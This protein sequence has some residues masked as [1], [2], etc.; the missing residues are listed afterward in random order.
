MAP[1]S[2]SLRSSTHTF[3]PAFASS[4]PHASE[5]TPLPTMTASYSAIDERSELL[6]GDERALARPE[7]LH[8]CEHLRAAILGEVEPELLRFDPDRVET[9]LLAEYE[10]AL[11]TDE[12]R[13]IRLQRPRG[14]GTGRAPAP[15]PAGKGGLAGDRLPR[16]ERVAGQL[17]HASRDFTDVREIEVGLHAV[18][19]AQR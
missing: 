14:G 9:A 13:G 17:L 19:R 6:V 12:R 7:F 2:Q 1:P 5:V 10:T 4:A 8:A 16:L 11:R 18:Q 3:Q 15:R